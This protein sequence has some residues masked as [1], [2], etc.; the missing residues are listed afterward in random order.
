[1]RNRAPAGTST[2]DRRA[3]LLSG[4]SAAIVAPVAAL[5]FPAL[6]IAPAGPPRT[7]T[8]AKWRAAL[9]RYRRAH[10]AWEAAFDR[11]AAAYEAYSQWRLE[12]AGMV[13]SITAIP[14]QEIAKARRDFG[15]DDLCD[16]EGELAG[17][18]IEALDSLLATPVPDLQALRQ[19]VAL[20][21]ECEREPVPLRAL[22]A[23]LDRLTMGGHGHA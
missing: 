12:R 1:M 2:A 16:R 20:I 11:D 19:K 9:S 7:A 6:Q 23:D 4:V 8:E 5:P 13:Q 18:R 3:A 22:L 15:L 17:E 14:P 21:I 10:S